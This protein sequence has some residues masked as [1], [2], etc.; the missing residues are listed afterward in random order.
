MHT[1]TRPRTALLALAA[2]CAAAA[3]LPALAA[4][5]PPAAP[6]RPVTDTYFGT[7]VVDNYR[8]LENLD[9]P[10]VQ[11]WMKAQAEYTRAALER[12]PGRAALL[13]R[14]HALNNADLSR[15]GLI[16]RGERY[17]Y[18]IVEP[19]AQQPKLYY[20]D[21]L[22]GQDHL[23]LDPSTLGAGSSTHY[24]LDFYTPSWDG[25]LVAYGISAGGS[26]D[27]VLHVLEV[28]SGRTLDEAI[29][30]T[31]NSVVAWRPDNKSFFY[32]RYAKRTPQLRAAEALYNART[33]LHTLGSRASGDGDPAVFGRGVAAA[34][35]VPE[36]QVTFLVLSPE[37][38]FALAVANH[39]AD[40]NPST[41]FVA[42]LASINGSDTPWRKLAD[43]EDGV[44]EFALRGDQ[45][46]FLS[47][48]GAP[49]FRLLRTSLAHPDIA[50]AE[51][52]VAQGRGVLTNFD[53]AGDALYV[54]ERNGALS[55]L[56]RVSFD[57]KSSHPVP[58]PF[59]GSIQGP[60]TDAHQPGALFDI[61]GWVQS[62][63][64][65]NYDPASD[66]TTDTGLTPPSSLDVSQLQAEEVFAV[67]Y[68]GTRIPLSILHRKGLTLDGSHPTILVGYG[69]Y[70]N[71]LD[72][73]FSPTT[74]AWLER[75]NVLAVAHVRGGGEY[76]EDWHLAGQKR[77]KLNTVFDFIACAQYLLDQHYTATR[78]LAGRGGSAGGITVGGALTWRPDM[79][80]VILDQVGLSDSLRVELT[81]NGPPN[82]SEFGSV[83]TEQGFHD[84]YAMGA[85]FHVR[86]DVAYPAVMFTTG[87]NDPRIA[88]WE[89]TKMAARV[90]AATRSGRPV[91]LRIDYDA[92]H[93]LGSTASQAETLTADLWS[94]TLWQ[95][96]DPEFQ[97]KPSRP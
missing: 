37:S 8:Y 93:G 82:I 32:D 13:Q 80:G 91:L 74:L 66:A 24:A 95:M 63:H 10:E 38:P 58:L 92:G 69:S 79:F 4:D 16:R 61:Q 12:L 71:P 6:I 19:G 68:D 51:V 59:E 18:R 25:R 46:Y 43:V 34:V 39:N 70:G 44:T 42:P 84:L 75:G 76:G 86:D 22:H 5:L 45:L 62:A 23:L 83:Q 96:G 47:Q 65:F 73:G 77:T 1:V 30:R 41:L 17:F 11:A 67:S 14:I 20:R 53:I 2:A 94:F 33:Y 78:Y 48:H 27:S 89:V 56:L 28:S 7:E 29:D 57:G 52:I 87:A 88:P 31:S 21:G 60:I 81:P 72:P 54:R 55:R 15:R 49:R 26:E 90:Q 40:N 85:Y 3:S 35:P 64:V 50:H 36:G 9:D 97:P